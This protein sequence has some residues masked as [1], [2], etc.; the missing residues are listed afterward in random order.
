M[1]KGAMWVWKA[2]CALLLIRYEA[3]GKVLVSHLIFPPLQME[4]N[5]ANT[6][7]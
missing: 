1:A 3:L 4:N 6:Q 2:D 5:T 7:G